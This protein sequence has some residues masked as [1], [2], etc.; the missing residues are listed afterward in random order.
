MTL[1]SISNESR[2]AIVGHLAEKSNGKI[3]LIVHGEQGKYLQSVAGSQGLMDVL[4]L[5]KDAYTGHKDGLYQTALAER[6]PFTSF[7]FDLSGHGE[8]EGEFSL[9]DIAVRWD[10][11]ASGMHY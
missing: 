2:E 8:S 3:I 6:L 9:G 4:L 11:P 5:T 7:R 10:T 1:T